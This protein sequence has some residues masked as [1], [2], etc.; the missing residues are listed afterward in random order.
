M[1]KDSQ[2]LY[3]AYQDITQKAAD[4]QYAAAVLGWDQEVYM[5]SKGFPYRGRQLATLATQAHELLTSE[6]YG[7]ILNELAARENLNDTQQNNVRLSMEDYEKNRKLPPS[8]V[9]ELTR[10][11]S[12]SFNAWIKAREENNYSVYQPQ[13][14]KMIALKRKQAELYGYEAH[15]YNALLDDYEKG[16][17]VAILDPIFEMVKDQLPSFLKKITEAQQ[18]DNS[19]FHQHFPKQQQWDFSIYVL[20]QMG[21]DFEAGRQDISEHPFTTSFAPTDVR[22]TTRVDEDNF[23]SLLWSSIHEGGHA[24]YEQGLPASEY[25]LPLGA[26]ASLSIHESQSRLWENC[27][28]RSLPFWKYFYP[29]LQQYFPQQLIR[30]SPEEF[31]NGVNRV[32]PS[33]VRTEAD[34]VTYHFHVMIRY[35]IEKRL[36]E[37][38]LGSKELAD[39]WNSMYKK[40]LGVSATDDKKGVL[41]D[42]HWSHGSFG[43]FPTYSLGSFYAAQF[44]E[45]AQKDDKGLSM[46]IENGKFD[47]LLHW[48]RE[49]IHCYGRRY[50]SEELCQKVTGRGLDF[51][52]FMRYLENKYLMV[53]EVS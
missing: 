43:Y 52:S 19:F 4:L 22:I 35:E 8:F 23:A 34:E 33:L 44:F 21:Y 10:Q 6:S 30:V 40:Y 49:N 27:V 53:H 32:Q 11:T 26:A 15:P 38:A 50:R 36:I 37:G 31:Y 3:K 17:T 7:A 39:E 12:V 47:N 46:Q 41:Q 51:T 1:Q 24:L 5:P 25:G 18:V 28:G 45:Q 9:D 13:L 42:V 20:K 48:L 14:D 16:I 2:E 29:K